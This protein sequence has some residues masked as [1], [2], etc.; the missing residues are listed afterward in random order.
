MRE[1]KFRAWYPSEARMGKPGM[2]PDVH[3]SFEGQGLNEL[4]GEVQELGIVLLQYTGLKDKNGREIYE[5]DIVA[6]THEKSELVDG[7]HSAWVSRTENF[8]VA[9]DTWNG[10]DNETE[11]WTLK[12]ERPFGEALYPGDLSN[13]H[14]DCEVIGNIYENP[15]LL[16]EQ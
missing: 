13:H 3:S 11:T 8:E 10:G 7:K 12:D 6:V 1:I 5:G 4:I 14:E 2:W 16:K 9:W 15:E